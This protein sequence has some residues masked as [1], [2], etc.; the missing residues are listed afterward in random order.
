MKKILFMNKSF[1]LLL[2]LSP[3]LSLA[4]FNDSIH[5]H[6]RFSSAGV[7]NQTNDGN[8]YV[9]TNS[10]NLNAKK[11]NVVFN[12]SLNWIYG[13]SQQTLTNND[14]GAHG[15]VDL[16]KGRHKLYSWALITYDKSYSLQINNRLQVGAGVAYNFIDSPDL[17]INLSDGFL[18][19][20][21][22][23]DD[24]EIGHD[25][26]SI[27]RNSLRLVYHWSIKDRF[28]IDGAHFY[29]PSLLSIGDYIIQSSSSLSLKLKKWL[30]I[31]AA[32][33]YNMVSRTERETLLF[34]YGFIVEKYF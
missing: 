22:D 13:E 16:Y 28:I 8:S 30:S 11:K 18:Y 1:F 32:L 6:V 20:K 7:I 21:G 2:L 17:R 25:L 24:P 29:Q 23:V 15:D 14:F 19:E 9:L 4:Q 3:V 31:T 26:Y 33:T 34:T 5:Y 27:P 12:A 10:F